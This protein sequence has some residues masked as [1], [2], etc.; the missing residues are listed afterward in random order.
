M[1]GYNPSLG[2]CPRKE[3]RVLLVRIA[4]GSLTMQLRTDVQNEAAIRALF[5][6]D[7]P[8]LVTFRDMVT[9]NDVVVNFNP[10]VPFVVERLN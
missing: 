10:N 5:D 1:R 7:Y 4:Y 3:V 9:G 8:G 2:C 6:G